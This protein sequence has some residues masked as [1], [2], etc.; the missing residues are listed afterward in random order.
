MTKQEINYHFWLT[1]T[2]KATLAHCLRLADAC[3]FR[4]DADSVATYITDLAEGNE[5]NESSSPFSETL[6]GRLRGIFQP[7]HLML[8]FACLR[9]ET[10]GI[11]YEFLV[12]YGLF[13][14]STG[15]YFGIKAVS[16]NDVSNEA[17]ITNAE[18]AIATLSKRSPRLFSNSRLRQRP[19]TDNAENGTYWPL[20]VPSPDNCDLTDDIGFLHRIYRDFKKAFPGMMPVYDVFRD[21]I[22]Q[23]RT[24]NAD[25][26]DKLVDKINST[27]A[28]A[29]SGELFR[30]FIA[31][32]CKREILVGC[33]NGQWRFNIHWALNRRGH[34]LKMTKKAAFDL[35]TVLFPIMAHRYSTTRSRFIP[36]KQLREL[37]LDVDSRP[38]GDTW[39]RQKA[40]SPDTPYYRQCH[41]LCLALMGLPVSNS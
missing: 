14:P 11:N 8:R 30:R 2:V 15:L 22:E 26:M 27:F 41:A 7:K 24:E 16:D 19:L 6:R 38:F 20:W 1:N 9:D 12:E 31:N 21:F 35:L 3:N 33:G 36:W 29:E 5:R 40:P 17:F 39:Q 10:A 23:P 18:N 34:P 25:A 32:A 13:E 4:L 28:S 37:L